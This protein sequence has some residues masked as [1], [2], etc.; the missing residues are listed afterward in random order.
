MAVKRTGY[1]T[2]NDWIHAFCLSQTIL[3]AACAIYGP[4]RFG[5][6]LPF[7]VA[8]GLSIGF[9][10]AK[11]NLISTQG[12]VSLAAG[13]ILVVAGTLPSLTLFAVHRWRTGTTITR[14]AAS[15][16]TASY[17]GRQLS[18][19]MLM[20]IVTAFAV[21]AVAA[22]AAIT[23]PSDPFGNEH[24]YF[25]MH[26]WL[27]FF[28]CLSSAPALLVVFRPSW[29]IVLA[30][31]FFFVMTFVEPIAFGLAAPLIFENKG[32]AEV[33]SWDDT[34][35]MV[36]FSLLWQGQTLVATVTYALLAR[37]AGFRMVFPDQSNDKKPKP[38][39]EP[40]TDAGCV[41]D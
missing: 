39:G 36:L 5:I 2:Q 29:K 22:R 15:V 7:I 30:C 16:C 17:Q 24:D 8:W 41:Q 20:A 18:L 10:L 35:R 13:A 28:P 26:A 9:F 6:R 21:A 1:F 33:L 38:S 3:L 37:A 12:R 34:S 27:A 25:V 4:G 11:A 31:C 32:L 19:R 40:E 23:A 14:S